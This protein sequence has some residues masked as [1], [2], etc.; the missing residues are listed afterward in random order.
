M[1]ENETLIAGIELDAKA[2]GVDL[3]Q[4]L[5]RILEEWGGQ[6]VIEPM[7]DERLAR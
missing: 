3:Q 7:S 1:M 5:K 6:A 4:A 2:L